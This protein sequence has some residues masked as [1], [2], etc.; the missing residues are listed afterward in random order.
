[1]IPELWFRRILLAAGVL[2]LGGALIF[3]PVFPKLRN[4][5]GLPE[6][7]HPL[8]P[9]LLSLWTLFFGFA[10]LRLAFA[11]TPERL[12]LQVAAAGKASFTLLLIAFWLHGVLPI[13]APLAGSSDLFFAM[14]FIVWLYQTRTVEKSPERFNPATTRNRHAS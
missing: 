6:A 4:L 11:T 8:Y 5:T 12:F 14:V 9:W 13:Q 7:G 2:N 3:A 1:L 10:Y